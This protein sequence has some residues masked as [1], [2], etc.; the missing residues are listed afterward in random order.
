M[1]LLPGLKN[2]NSKSV[3]ALIGSQVCETSAIITT[4]T[5]TKLDTAS[6]FQAVL[7]V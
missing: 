3:Q 2:A 4:I 1:T 6:Y 5:E 7:D